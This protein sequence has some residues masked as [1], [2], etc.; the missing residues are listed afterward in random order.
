MVNKKKDYSKKI[1][2]SDFIGKMK[3]V[4][5]LGSGALKIGEAGEFDYSG[6]Q[7]LKALKEEKIE[8]VLVNP[9]IATIQT[10]E[11]FS[12]KT[13]FL[14]V[15]ADFVEKVI[16]KERPDGI[17]L[18]FGGQTAL[19][20]GLE[21]HNRKVLQKF[22]VKILGSPIESIQASEDR[23]EFKERLKKIDVS[24]A[25]SGVASTLKEALKVAKKIG[26]PVLVRSG[27]S[28]GG[29]GS[30]LAYNK[31]QLENI[32]K[33]ALMHSSQILIEEYLEGWK[34]IEYEVVRDCDDNI[35]TVCNMENMDPMGVH[36]GESIVVAPSQTLSNKDYNKLREISIKVVRNLKIVGECNI[37]FA[38]NPKSSDVDYRV[39]EV[40][41]RL[42]RS[43]ALASKATGYPLA[44]IACKLSLGYRLSEI[45]NKVTKATS[46]FFE[47]ALDYVVVK[48]PRWDLD[49]FEGASLK[50]GSSMQSVGEV[51][52]IG[53][54][55]EEAFQKSNRMVGIDQNR[56]LAS[57]KR[58]KKKYGNGNFNTTEKDIK[59]I[60]SM[61]KSPSPYRV[62]AIVEALKRGIDTREISNLCNID[63]WFIE[64]I[65]NIVDLM[66]EISSSKN[67]DRNFLK[68]IKAFG[69]SDKQIAILC[70][71]EEVEIRKI[72]K[73]YGI[74][75]K[76]NKI[77]TLA[78]EYPAKTNY[79]YLTYKDFVKKKDVS[80]SNKKAKKKNKKIIILGS[81]VYRI[82]SSVEFD[83]CAVSCALFLR[84]KGYETIVIN[85]NPETVSTD[86]DIC[87]KLYFDEL[88][89]ESVKEIYD[90]EN[91]FGIIVSMGGQEANNLALRLSRAGMNILG[92]S[93]ENIN[94]AENRY[95]FSKM[96]QEI[97][98]S[99]PAWKQLANVK[100]VYDF[101][102]KAGYPVLIR[103]SY[104]LSGSA[105]NVALNERDLKKYLGKATYISPEHPV[106]ISKFITGAKEIEVDAVA[107]N[108]NVK[109]AIISE[110][111]ENAGVH[112]GDATIV[113]PPQK[114]YIRTINKIK[115]TTGLIAKALNITGPFNIQF[116][117][118]E[119]EIKVIECNLRVSR[120]FPFVS[121]ISGI[122]LIKIA[123]DVILGNNVLNYP[124]PLDL[125]FVGMKAPQFSFF[126]IKGA[127]PILKVEMMSTGEVG[128][129]GD[130]IY[131]AYLKSI[132]STGFKLPKKSILLTIGGEKN[133][134]EFLEDAFILA[135]LGYKIYATHHTCDFLRGHNIK[136]QKLY[137]IHE[138][139]EP[140]VKTF[141]E[142][143]KI[144]LVV[145]IT[146]R[147]FKKEIKDDYFIRR[148]SI[149]CN[150]PLLTD[151]KASKLFVKALKR[152]KEGKINLTVK[153]R[154]DYFK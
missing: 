85:N 142:S 71:K 36:T 60:I 117:A 105:M 152:L 145:N 70:K 104:V 32:A 13:Y 8:T 77:D 24:T 141:L 26:Y 82:G 148:C 112:S 103:P 128:C 109:V 101:A 59:K 58:A 75:P 4:I 73:E 12:N 64:K 42:S 116:L 150:T 34:E 127:D 72:R 68:K 11:G 16:E 10:S 146:D 30:D 107:Q 38:L 88:S 27:Y 79:S 80:S 2:R 25:I 130:D 89:F 41:A 120:S 21:L 121:K 92:T 1:N 91:P 18:S 57:F 6:S 140:N 48:I 14:P 52:A 35:I 131:E 86:Y 144:D 94:N 55:F 20:C 110:H 124:I 97:N 119:N 47:P 22:K 132:I 53:R 87:D 151:M 45:K 111:I 63:I 76:V 61:I 125:D 9:N 33:I 56:L 122:D 100:D 37:Q 115:K 39:I 65:K 123:T 66:K 139:E 138:E 126:R 54:N 136:V 113:I 81:G 135:N 153:A 5:L 67:L 108:G 43:S 133:K 83:W 98:I 17:L 69:F 137:K 50:I 46:A 129:F 40:N 28:L 84:K 90:I 114:I 51:M 93:A 149:D 23:K 31:S 7:A 78:A 106:V 44:F 143:R 99:Q 118:K 102:K 29:Q 147:F 95:K 49:K 62:L 74:L 96:L 154:N 134:I 19:N 3:K 15:N